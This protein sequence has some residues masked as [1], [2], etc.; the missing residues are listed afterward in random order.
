MLHKLLIPFDIV[1]ITTKVTTE[2]FNAL[3]YI[4]KNTCFS[5]PQ[6]QA[7]MV[8][9]MMFPQHS[10]RTLQIL[11]NVTVFGEKHLWLWLPLGLILKIV[12]EF[13][14][15]YNI[16]VIIGTFCSIYWTLWV[17]NGLFFRIWIMENEFDCMLL[18]CY[19]R[20][21]EWI[22]TLCLPECQGTPGR[23]ILKIN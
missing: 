7:T 9:S 6:A 23:S 18:S 20:V 16:G 12:S 13:Y 3:S 22:H 21:S 8:F 11:L 10:K 4:C 17:I 19:V 2:R 1:E 15:F 5:I 14:C